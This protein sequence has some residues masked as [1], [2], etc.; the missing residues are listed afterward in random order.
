MTKPSPGPPVLR[1]AGHGVAQGEGQDGVRRT[2][3][4]SV[5]PLEKSVFCFALPLGITAKSVVSSVIIYKTA[6]N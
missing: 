3:P 1:C 2:R 6:S 5:L 4:H